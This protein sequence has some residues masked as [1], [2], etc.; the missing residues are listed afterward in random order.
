MGKGDC[1]ESW[2]YALWMQ[3][4]CFDVNVVSRCMHLCAMFA[5]AL[6]KSS[7]STNSKHQSEIS[8]E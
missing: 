7:L 1:L 2:Y 3:Q 6:A 8:S 4:Y 5:P